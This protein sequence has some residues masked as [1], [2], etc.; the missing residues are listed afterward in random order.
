MD[1]DDLPMPVGEMDLP[2]PAGEMDLPMPVGDVDLPMPAGD[3]PL[4]VKDDL[5][6]AL[7][8]DLPSAVDNLPAPGS[9]LPAIP[10]IG[11]PVAQD[12]LPAPLEEDTA[13]PPAD[14]DDTDG[15]EVGVNE[16]LDAALDMLPPPSDSGLEDLA[17]QPEGAQV[18]LKPKRSKKL[19]IALVIV[20]IIAVAGG[21]L[22][23]PLGPYGYLMI[24]D[25]LGRSDHEQT[26]SATRE[27]SGQAL[28]GDTAAEVAAAISSARAEQA[29]MDRFAPMA[30]YTAYLVF[31]DH[32]RFGG[33]IERD[34][35]GKRLLE[36]VV[37]PE[38][39]V[40]E[41]LAN[42]TKLAV[43]G[44]LDEAMSRAGAIAEQDSENVDA[45][46]VVAEIE[47]LRGN[48]EAAL[49][50]WGTAVNLE[51]TPRT[52]FGLARALLANGQT[53]AAMTSA[54]KVLKSSANHAGAR[55]L[56]ANVL[57]MNG[58]DNA[59]AVKLL[60]QITSAGPVFD[61]A[62]TS[63]KVE[64]YTL[65]GTVHLQ[66]GRISEAEKM[67]AEA[68]SLD[69]QANAPLIGNGTLFYQSS[70][71]SEALA[72]FEAALRNNPNSVEARIGKLKT[73]LALERA[74]ESLSLAQEFTKSGLKDARIS[75]WQGRAHEA[76]GDRESAE[77]GYRQAIELG[78]TAPIVVVAYV[79]LGSLLAAKGDNESADKVLAEAAKK[80]PN[81]A[82]LHQAK[83]EVALKAGRLGEAIDELATSLKL[84]ESNLSARFTL[85]DAC[86]RSRKLADAQAH[87]EQ[88]EKADAKYPGL[89]ALW[90]AIYAE[91]GETDRA[92]AKYNQALKASPDDADLQLRL[93]A[94]QVRTGQTSEALPLL[95]AVFRQRPTSAEVNHYL[96]R[97]LFFE[98]ARIA[99]ALRF[100]RTATTREPH[101]AEYHLYVAWAANEGGKLALAEKAIKAMLEIDQGSSDAL[102]Q[103]GILLHKQGSAND[104]LDDLQR[105]VAINPNRFEAY[106][107]M[108]LC[109]QEQSQWD[110]AAAAWRTAIEGRDNVAEWH[111]RLGKIVERNGNRVATAKHMARAT[112]LLEKKKGQL[113]G[114][115]ADA[116]RLLGESIGDSDRAKAIAAYKMYLKHVPPDAT[117]YRADVRRAILELGGRLR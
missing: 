99:E 116:Y 69:P 44:Q 86:V 84:D 81:N 26:L 47:L 63:E 87:L 109:H 6:M 79:A 9:N 32:L 107:T 23:E 83:G 97:A 67:F 27:N 95:R 7:S 104:A 11:L 98:G 77:K 110:A 12:N 52:E 55:A 58:D 64:A 18:K 60:E 90:G 74:K 25:T 13:S 10:E 49:V 111:Y 65:L 73:L 45:A 62:S 85:A 16:A 21:V 41:G 70:R 105:A 19:R 114:W 59:E 2:M 48:K 115:T 42:A 66:H 39:G 8:A 101:H 29:Q 106:A 22:P 31:M 102:W 36:Q 15:L 50:A 4:P 91:R 24:S 61:A 3:L 117:A 33:N 96:G 78:K 71:Y 5:P 93:A 112:Q 57:L 108:A 35:V 54:L 20:V 37:K 14:D 40:W 38:P 92:L 53:D 76:L 103:R 82:R 17:F 30:Y 34:A 100:L 75:Y 46:V 94:T 51:Q 28:A 88:L 1:D 89:A 68:L 113:P 56:R 43:E 72:R 80:F